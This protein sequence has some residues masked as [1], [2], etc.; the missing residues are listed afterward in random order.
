MKVFVARTTFGRAVRK[1][2]C[3]SRAFAKQLLA[4]EVQRVT[5]ETLEKTAYVVAVQRRV[6]GAT[7]RKRHPL[8]KKAATAIRSLRRSGR[9]T[10]VRHA[11]TT[12]RRVRGKL[13]RRC[14]VELRRAAVV[15]QSLARAR[16]SSRRLVARRVIANRLGCILRDAL[17]TRRLELAEIELQAT[18]ASEAEAAHLETLF[19]A[20][21]GTG[22]SWSLVDVEVGQLPSESG[23]WGRDAGIVLSKGGTLLDVALSSDG[24]YALD[25]MGRCWHWTPLNAP[26]LILARPRF[27][28]I[29]AGDDH[30]AAIDTNARVW[31]WGSNV[32]GELGLGYDASIGSRNVSAVTSP[33]LLPRLFAAWVGCGAHF[34]FARCLNHENCFYSWG[35]KESGVLGLGLVLDDIAEPTRV[36]ALEDRD[37]TTV[38]VGHNHCLGLD[39]L[40]ALWGWGSNR[41]S[42]LVAG[43]P[44]RVL[45]PIPLFKCSRFDAISCGGRHSVAIA[46]DHGTLRAWG[47][48]DSGQLG[49]DGSQYVVAC[50]AGWRTTVAVTT[51]GS[52]RF[53]GKKFAVSPV[54]EDFK[55]N[56][57]KC[58]FSRGLSLTLATVLATSRPD[59]DDCDPRRAL[60]SL[61]EARSDRNF[62]VEWDRQLDDTYSPS[63]SG[64][65]ARSV[66]YPEPVSSSEIASVASAISKVLRDRRDHHSRS[67][68]TTTSPP[69]PPPPPQRNATSPALQ[70]FYDALASQ[71]A[72]R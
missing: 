2:A 57:V 59:R 40:G 14:F 27:V 50:A 38:A 70:F 19:N 8:A 34:S 43:G 9:L 61:S 71:S 44:S 65:L 26:S 60:D 23:C 66:S 28:S 32:H 36:A 17:R 42:Q 54:A 53:W 63:T 11:T 52:L 46:R 68:R 51:E 64:H 18:A 72:R 22:G 49:G 12:Q 31:T 10:A 29:S 16:Q 20:P 24:S 47:R 3:V 4:M 33:T 15:A 69:P 5:S 67:P 35:A 25:A 41:F 1:L 13:A 56:E 55:A 37:I 39:R 48:N 30:V 58:V 21:L 45:L 7:C 62:V 6:R